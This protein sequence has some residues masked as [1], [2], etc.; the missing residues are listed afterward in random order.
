MCRSDLPLSAS[1]FIIV[2]SFVMQDV[3]AMRKSSGTVTG[4]V[5]INGF[6]QVRI[7]GN[8]YY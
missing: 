7:E 6:P 5:R 3:V 4:E 1:E 2:F 8:Q